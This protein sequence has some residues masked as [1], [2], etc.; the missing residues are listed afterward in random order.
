MHSGVFCG[1]FIIC[2]L[3]QIEGDYKIRI[4]LKTNNE[5]Q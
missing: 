5:I 3:G 4:I 2:F 1:Y